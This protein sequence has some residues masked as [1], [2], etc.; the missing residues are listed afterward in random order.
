V[1]SADMIT[2][3]KRRRRMPSVDQLCTG[4]RVSG[5]WRRGAPRGNSRLDKS[6]RRNRTRAVYVSISNQIAACGEWCRIVHSV[7]PC[8][9]RLI[10][11]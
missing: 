1:F 4:L 8:S 10:Q 7:I 2:G 3:V 6:S 9:D 5:T 11:R